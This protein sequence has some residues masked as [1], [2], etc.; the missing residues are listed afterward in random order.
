MVEMGRGVDV[1]SGGLLTNVIVDWR[2]K[3]DDE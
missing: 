3:M 2:E 1:K